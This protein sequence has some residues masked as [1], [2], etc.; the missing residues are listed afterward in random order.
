MAPCSVDVWR[1][2]IGTR[3][4][5]FAGLARRFAKLERRFTEKCMRNEPPETCVHWPAAIVDDRCEN[6]TLGKEILCCSIL[7]SA[8]S[9]NLAK[10]GVAE[11]N[12]PDSVSSSKSQI[13]HFIIR[14][15]PRLYALGPL[16]PA[17]CVSGH[18]PRRLSTADLVGRAKRRASAKPAVG[19]MIQILIVRIWQYQYIPAK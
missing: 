8:L 6:R 7:W 19:N 3:E 13:G 5:S 12:I 1:C 14:L 16:E 11:Q 10:A 15:L 18:A 9:S 17:Q 2:R 4:K